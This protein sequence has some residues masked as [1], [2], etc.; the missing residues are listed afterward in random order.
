MS[1][2]MSVLVNEDSVRLYRVGGCYFLHLTSSVGS[3]PCA[4]SGSS[5]QDLLASYSAA[6]SSR[7]SFSYS[8]LPEDLEV[9]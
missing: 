2:R 4:F 9:F 7:L 1:S 5:F 8:D 3:S 6:F